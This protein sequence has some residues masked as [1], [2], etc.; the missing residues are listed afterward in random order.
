M[1]V[2]PET[3]REALTL[4]EARLGLQFPEDRRKDF[5]HALVEAARSLR[6]RG[7]E[8]LIARLTSSPGTD[9][10]W[11]CLTRLLT[12]SE[13]YFFRD[14]ACFDALEQHVLPALIE[15]R[16]ARRSLRLW[17]AACATGEEPYSLAILV[18][19]L[20][21]DRAGWNITILGTDLNAA[22]LE[23]ARRGAYREWSL[24]DVPAH[25]RDCHF[26]DEGSMGFALDPAIRRMVTF[27]RANLADGLLAAVPA[28]SMDLILC[29]NALMYLSPPAALVAVA[30]LQAALAKDGWLLVAPSEASAER[31]LPLAP[32]N[33]PGTIF[34]KAEGGAP[35]TPPAARTPTALT[36]RSPPFRGN[37]PSHAGVAPA[38]ATPDAR[39]LLALARVSADRRD[40]SQAQD[41]C[42]AAIAADRLDPVAHRLLAAIHQER[43]EVGAAVASLR[44]ALYLDPDSAEDHLGLGQLLVRQGEDRRGQKHLETAARLARETDTP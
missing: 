30:G 20:L 7:P 34:F 3:S 27:E 43:G 40:L 33:F 1:R 39:A 9:P 22:S 31:F 4:V 15:A 10:E 38:A 11:Q 6:L 17:S 2:S 42:R 19:R 14:R 37:A 25:V 36:P 35:A 8:A 23:A 16:R 32:V 44:R 41:L 5:D 21:P 28:S 12:V 29:R 13:T 18:D 24:R 26:A